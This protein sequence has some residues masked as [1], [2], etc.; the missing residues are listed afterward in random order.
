MVGIRDRDRDLV[1]LLNVQ[2][3]FAQGGAKAEICL[4]RGEVVS[5]HLRQVRDGTQLAPQISKNCPFR[6]VASLGVILRNADIGVFSRSM[7]GIDTCKG[8]N[9][10]CYFGGRSET[11]YGNSLCSR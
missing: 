11:L 10:K 3:A 5:Q 4:K 9:P 2:L 7:G 8:F 6:P 1:A